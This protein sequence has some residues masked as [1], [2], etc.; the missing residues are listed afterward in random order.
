MFL[1]RSALIRS[2]SPSL[3]AKSKISMFSSDFA[4]RGARHHGDLGLLDQPAQR[5]L[6]GCPAVGFRDL[7]R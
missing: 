6:G 2:I 7:D 4:S 1:S 5:H 3:S